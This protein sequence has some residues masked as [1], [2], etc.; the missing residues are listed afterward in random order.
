MRQCG[1]HDELKRRSGVEPEKP[2]QQG[3]DSIRKGTYVFVSPPD[4]PRSAAI[5]AS[6]RAPEESTLVEE[7][8]TLVERMILE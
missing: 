4:A 5:L 6:S 7:E 8:S 1:K 3:R 2:H